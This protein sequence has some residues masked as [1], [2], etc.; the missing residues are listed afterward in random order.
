MTR[1]TMAGSIYLSV[2]AVMPD[3][4]SSGFQVQ[5]IPWIGPTLNAYMPTWIT[6][7]LGVTFMF[8]G[9]SLLIVIQVAIDFVQQIEAQLV[10]RHYDG[11]LKSGK[12]RSRRVL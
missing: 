1:L 11:F 10:M 4:L 6:Q 2:V 12:S 9:T 8:G 5:Y 7:G 3:F